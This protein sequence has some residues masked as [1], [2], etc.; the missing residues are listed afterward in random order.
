MSDH[1][2]P[3][4]QACVQ[5]VVTTAQQYGSMKKS[6]RASSPL[7]ALCSHAI[8]VFP[9]TSLTSLHT[10]DQLLCVCVFVS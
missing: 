1:L 8:L 3:K 4:W 2:L 5:P 10:L 9:H 6:K 7:I